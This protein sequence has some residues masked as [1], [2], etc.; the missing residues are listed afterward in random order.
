MPSRSLKASWPHSANVSAAIAGV[1][2][3]LASECI[4]CAARTGP[5]VG[6]ATSIHALMPMQ[7]QGEQV[8]EPLVMDVID[9]RARRQLQHEHRDGADA[10]CEADIRPAPALLGQIDREKRSEAGLHRRYEQI[11]SVQSD[12]AAKGQ[13]GLVMPFLEVAVLR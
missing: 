7:H 9:Q 3:Q 2:M 8:G 4:S 1:R 5:I 13:H 10:E 11:E 12:A 6:V